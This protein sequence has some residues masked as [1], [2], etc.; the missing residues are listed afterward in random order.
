MEKATLGFLIYKIWQIL[1]CFAGIFRRAQTLKLWG[2]ILTKLSIEFDDYLRRLTPEKN[3]RN[4]WFRDYWEDLFDCYVDQR[5]YAYRDSNLRKRRKLCNPKL[6]YKKSICRSI[7][8]F[9]GFKMI[10]KNH[11]YSVAFQFL[12]AHR[13][14]RNC[15]KI[16]EKKNASRIVCHKF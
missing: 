9:I 15:S 10:W 8:H 5:S 6:R 4:L 3:E 7:H 11:Q 14:I 13:D 16:R 1:K 2:V 12:K